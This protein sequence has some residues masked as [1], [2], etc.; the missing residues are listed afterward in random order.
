MI[1]THRYNHKVA[2]YG[3][4]PEYH[5]YG[6]YQDYGSYDPQILDFQQH[7]AESGPS[8][9]AWVPSTPHAMSQPQYSMN[10][11]YQILPTSAL[12][13]G[14]DLHGGNGSYYVGAAGLPQLNA[15]P[16]NLGATTFVPGLKKPRESR[17][18]SHRDT[19]QHSSSP[20]RD[21]NAQVLST[22]TAH[23]VKFGQSP[24]LPIMSGSRWISLFPP[25][26]QRTST[27]PLDPINHGTPHLASFNS[28]SRKANHNRNHASGGPRRMPQP[29]KSPVPVPGTRFSPSNLDTAS[30]LRKTAFFRLPENIREKI[31]CHVFGQPQ[32]LHYTT[33]ARIEF[34]ADDGI[35]NLP[36]LCLSPKIIV[37]MLNMFT[38]SKTWYQDAMLVWFSR[39]LPFMVTEVHDILDY[40]ILE[41]YI[42]WECPSHFVRFSWTCPAPKIQT[43]AIH[44]LEMRTVVANCQ[45]DSVSFK[46]NYR[47]DSSNQD[48]M[49]AEGF[50]PA[51]VHDKPYDTNG[52]PFAHRPPSEPM[53]TLVVA[54][55]EIG[56]LFWW[57]HAWY[58]RVVFNRAHWSRMPAIFD[59][60]LMSVQHWV[61]AEGPVASRKFRFGFV[62]S[63]VRKYQFELERERCLAMANRTIQRWKDY[64]QI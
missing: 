2:A 29:M 45:E 62:M 8:T 50:F 32:L 1:P 6:A 23:D 64:T 46:S 57:I 21:D 3:P 40:E 47:H 9:L 26:V 10:N 54:D 33:S 44:H 51:H 38:A 15:M 53:L 41:R 31:W 34:G 42:L 39:F 13:Y 43:L 14:F 27:G 60:F 59:D 37:R 58:E 52:L 19:T 11:D 35:R 30:I 28:G 12:G 49:T 36:P 63:H 25:I 4:Q 55:G 17:V 61:T 24:T 7:Q 22:A 18:R 20:G 16:F 56:S 48:T 5:T